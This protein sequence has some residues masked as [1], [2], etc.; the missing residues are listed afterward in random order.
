MFVGSKYSLQKL[1]S[2]IIPQ[3]HF[4]HD[5]MPKKLDEEPCS[6]RSEFIIMNKLRNHHAVHDKLFPEIE[7]VYSRA[8]LLDASNNKAFT[9]NR[10]LEDLQI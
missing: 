9:V 5:L 2:V 6:S 3:G 1:V 8:Q 7:E 4:S 10:V